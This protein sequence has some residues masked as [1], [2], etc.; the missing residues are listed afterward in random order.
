MTLRQWLF[1]ASNRTVVRKEEFIPLVDND[2]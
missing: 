2:L 1:L